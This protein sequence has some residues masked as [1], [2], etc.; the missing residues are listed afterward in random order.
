M[1]DAEP[2]ARRLMQTVVQNGSRAGDTVSNA[3]L[4]LIAVGIGIDGKDREDAIGFA[5]GRGWIANGTRAGTIRLTQ[6]GWECGNA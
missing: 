4:Q 3:Q 5:A 6:A 2:N 1:S